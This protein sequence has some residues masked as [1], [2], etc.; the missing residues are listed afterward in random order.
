MLDYNIKIG[1]KKYRSW[2][3]LV[4]YDKKQLYIHLTKTLPDG[5]TWSDFL[6]GKLHIDHIIP[7]SAFNFSKPEHIDFKRCW[8]LSNLRLIPA[9][10]NLI[11]SNKIYKPFQTSLRI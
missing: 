11:K 10:E 8:A 6:A 3:D 9:K 4:D 7:I 5:Y 1:N 2:I